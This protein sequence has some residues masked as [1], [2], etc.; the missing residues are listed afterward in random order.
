MFISFLVLFYAVCPALVLA[1]KLARPKA[2]GGFSF[3]DPQG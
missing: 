1:A 2:G 3:A